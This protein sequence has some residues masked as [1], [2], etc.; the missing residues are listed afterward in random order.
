MSSKSVL[1]LVGLLGMVLPIAADDANTLSAKEKA[2]GW[3]LLFDGKSLAGWRI[4][5]RPNRPTEIGEGWKVEAGLLKKLARVRGGEIITERQFDDFELTWEWRLEKGANSGVKYM[6]TEQRLEAPGYEY[7]MIDDEKSAN[8]EP[9]FHTA[10]FY[11]VVPPVADKGYKPAGE[12]NRSRILVNGNHVEHWLN[13]KK[14]VEFELGSE[15][16]KQGVARSKFNKFPD[17]GQ[18]MKGHIMLTDHGDEAWF[19]N[20][21]LREITARRQ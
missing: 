5:K 6:V 15:M 2:A 10:S 8:L 20:I 13:G 1:L 18:K 7:Q 19:R 21:K 16:V 4:Y 3:Q 9:R 12:W 17:F 14:A 11:E